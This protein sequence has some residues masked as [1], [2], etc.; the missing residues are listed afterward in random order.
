MRLQK[1]SSMILTAAVAAS[2]VLGAVPAFADPVNWVGENNGFWD[3]AANWSP[4]SPVAADNAL[5]SSFDTEL[6]SGDFN[7]LSLNGTGRFTLSGGSLTFTNASS[8]GAFDMTGGVIDGVGA[9]SISG[10]SNWT[11]GDMNGAGSTTF[12]GD[13][14]L[15]GNNTRYIQQ[16]AVNFAVTTTWTGGSFY[17]AFGAALTNSGAFLDQNTGN[18][19]ISNPYGVADSS[20]VNTGT[21]TKSGA[22]ATSI[23]IGFSN[24]GVV[25]VNVGTLSLSG[26]GS[27]SGSFD[28]ASGATLNFAGG[29]HD[30]SGLVTGTGTSRMLVSSG[31]VN[32]ASIQLGTLSI[33]SGATVTIQAIPG[34]PLSDTIATVPE[35]S[36]LVLLAAAFLMLAYFR[37]R[38]CVK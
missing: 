29:T 37:A 23:G 35:P 20:F 31:T 33:G 14:A 26:G 30:L 28:V 32:A 6:R 5:L 4:A 10:A 9:L 25:N 22:G 19:S 1:L 16:R 3:I 15:S 34:G 2:L 7:V 38:K 13:L 11:G 24:A 21:Y 36:T 8:V 12:N 18:V 27:S 17:T